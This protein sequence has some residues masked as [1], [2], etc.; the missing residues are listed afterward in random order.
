MQRARFSGL[1]AYLTRS[2]HMKVGITQII[3]KD[4][5]LADILQLC[6]DAEYEAVELVFSEGGDPEVDMSDDE[7]RGVRKQCD[8]AGIEIGSSIAW[9][10]ERGCFLSADKAEREH[11]KKCLRR[12][13]EIAHVLGVDA[14]LL[15]P[16]QL[17]ADATYQ[18]AW[19]W[20]LGELKEIA[21]SA[22]EK[23]VTVGIENVW[24]K[25]LLSPKE[26]ADFV[27]AVGSPRV[28]T[29]LDT[30][31][32]MFYGF[33]EHWIRGLG[34]RIARVHFKDFVRREKNFVPL[35]DGDTDWPTIVQD[36]RNIGYDR[37]VIHEVGGDRDLQIEMAK[38][39][40]KIVSL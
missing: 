19:D 37:P 30:A 15:H 28:G 24:N 14:V 5:P 34:D 32:M 16:G 6:V 29:Y 23:G 39:M 33:P 7:I 20:M 2:D 10:A 11:G 4:T 8:E 18:E 27:D 22:E 1:S 9:Y 26:M 17:T 3:L 31:N 13:I 21:P 12:S 36:L 38:R 25:F 35:M 40:K